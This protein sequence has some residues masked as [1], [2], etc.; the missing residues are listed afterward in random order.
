[1][2]NEDKL[3]DVTCWLGHAQDQEQWLHRRTT[4]EDGRE[5]DEYETRCDCGEAIRV[6]LEG[7]RIIEEINEP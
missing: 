2:R 6:F 5:V 7:G 4:L 3:A 1:M